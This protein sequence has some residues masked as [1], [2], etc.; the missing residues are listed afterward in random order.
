MVEVQMADEYRSKRLQRQPGFR[1][2]VGSAVAGIHQIDRAIDH[3]R[4]RRLRTLG[5]GKR[6]TMGS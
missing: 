6:A 1:Q 5:V 3:E 4:T 2:L